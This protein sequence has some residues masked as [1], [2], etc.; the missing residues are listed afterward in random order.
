MKLTLTIEALTEDH[1]ADTLEMIAREV[2]LG[3]TAG[4]GG[5]PDEYESYNYDV[6]MWAERDGEV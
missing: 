4:G 6:D 5:D 3:F 1:L 2:S